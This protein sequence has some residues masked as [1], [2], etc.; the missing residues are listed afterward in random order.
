MVLRVIPLPIPAEHQHVFFGGYP[1]QLNRRNG[2]SGGTVEARQTGAR[3]IPEPHH[4]LLKKETKQK[5]GSAGV[6]PPAA[7]FYFSSP[8]TF[9]MPKATPE[10]AG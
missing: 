8:M 6:F 2:I 10:L 7:R 4:L 1:Q 3:L 5:A 9:A